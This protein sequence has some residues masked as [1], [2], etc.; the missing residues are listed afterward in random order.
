MEFL[1]YFIKSAGILT[2]FYVVYIL[3]LRKDTYFS[4]KRFYLLT[5]VIAALTLPLIT[6]TTITLIERAPLTQTTNIA[7]FITSATSSSLPVAEA[8]PF[9]WVLLLMSI[10][11]LGACIFLFKFFLQLFSLVRL[12][13]SHNYKRVGPYKFIES[14]REIA[15][16]S[17][18]NYIV[19]NPN[20]H[21][22]EELKMILQHEKIHASQWHSI[23]LLF[24]NLMR[25]FQWI[26]P[27]SWLYKISLEAN[28]EFLADT[29]TVEKI[30]NKIQYQL[31]LVK[32]SSSLPVPALTN[33]FY[34][35]F[36][37]KRI[38]ML[39]KASSNKY[40][41]LKL[42]AVLPAL[43]L[44]LWSF[45]TV[46]VIKY[47]EADTPIS[48]N[49]K[50]V[51]ATLISEE[52]NAI[53]DDAVMTSANHNKNA[54]AISVVNTAGQISSQNRKSASVTNQATRINI[55]NFRYVI[56]SNTTD[57][58]L[59]TIKQELKQEHQTDFNYTTKRNAQGEITGIQIGYTDNKKNNGNY[60][61]SS[62]NPIASFFFYQENGT[63]GFGN[64]RD[65][66]SLRSKE[67]ALSQSRKNL[68]HNRRE[69]IESKT[70]MRQ[71][72]M[73]KKREIM[74]EKQVQENATRY[75]FNTN[76][77]NVHIDTTDD[78]F[79][80]SEPLIIVDG[81]VYSGD[82]KAIS[83]NE[84]A[85]INVLKDRKAALKYG[86]KNNNGVVEIIL[87]NDG[88]ETEGWAKSVVYDFTNGNDM[89]TENI[90]ITKNTTDAD[91]EN[92]KKE[93]N[94]EGKD[95]NYKR[96]KR[97]SQGEI[98]NI[99]ITLNDNKGN[100]QSISKQSN[101]SNAIEEILIEY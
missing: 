59:E 94:Q 49:S 54:N 7:Q 24:A 92:I 31:T 2:L 73:K 60:N 61:I 34:Q 47:K 80:G 96:V 57:A 74:E 81:K 64:I 65:K 25:A 28:L 95:F 79:K 40:N 26:N 38:I 101:N 16:F 84:I 13:K 37:K 42:I 6:F 63:T 23:D 50:T 86:V 14:D 69:L 100:K 52:K 35:S 39:N 89:N 19:F 3:V 71:D 43:A 22:P 10:Y 33:N 9:N 90:Y 5:G 87:K 48:N 88:N 62:D 20:T 15:P 66:D 55:N 98:T 17:F 4:A 75:H 91:L 46:E 29:Q 56:T 36:I 70:E 8:E 41:Q 77:R 21:S 85:T 72:M 93:M 18:F 83:P 97:N 58:K 51:N 76:G 53:T 82:L 30:D 99:K 78:F 32:A 44:F 67:R 1:N 27:F 11:I 45:N 68:A 12:L